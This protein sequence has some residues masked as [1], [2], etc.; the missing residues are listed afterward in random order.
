MKLEVALGTYEGFVYGFGFELE[1]SGSVEERFAYNTKAGCIKCAAFVQ[2]GPRAGKVLV[3]G[4]SDEVVRIYDYARRIALG[5]IRHHDGT[6]TSLNFFSS[7]HML[8]SSED[9]SIGI[10]RV[11]DWTLLHILGGHKN[12]VND[13]SVHPSGRMAV[14]VSSDRTLRLWNLLEGRCA[15]IKRTKGAGQLVEWSPSGTHF[16]VAVEMDIFIYD[17]G[18][19][20]E[21]E[22][23][24]CPIGSRTNCIVWA[25]DNLIAAATNGSELKFFYRDG[26][27][28]G[29]KSLAADEEDFAA[30]RV[31]AMSFHPCSELG[32][33]VS[34]LILT[35]T[36]SGALD[37][38]KVSS[39]KDCVLTEFE[40]LLHYQV[41]GGPR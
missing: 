29:A 27:C 9:G 36:S 24:R 18:S 7:S 41:K 16:A 4:G 37:V 11:H 2:G 21:A 40:S 12:A 17:A 25:G 28:L 19:E 35:A 31:R 10:W 3:T 13:L 6:I 26:S 32:A 8:S 22:P 15:F 20:D 30:G 39:E 1:S 5:E 33:H 34:G 38:W 14:S 23:I